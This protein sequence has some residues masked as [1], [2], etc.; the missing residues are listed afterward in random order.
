MIEFRLSV[1]RARSSKNGFTIVELLVVI[2]LIGILVGLLLPAVQAARGSAA[3]TQCLNNARQIALGLHQ[4]HDVHGRLPPDNPTDEPN[5]PSKLLH[6]TALILP[7]LEQA[8]LWSEA[9]Q[10]CRLDSASYNNPP[11]VGHVTIVKAFVCPS[12]SRLYTPL[13]LQDGSQAAFTS[14]IGI[15]GSPRGGSFVDLSGTLLFKPAAGVLGQDPG[16]RFAQISDGLS[17]TLMVGE[18]PPPAIANAGRWYSRIVYEPN[19]PGPDGAM[20]IPQ[21]LLF[22]QDTCEVSG[23]GFGPGRIDNPCDRFHFWSLHPG[24]GNFVF[25]DA[26]VRYVPYTA[27]ALL[28]ALATRAGDEPVELP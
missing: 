28:P 14:Y 25:A 1:R 11:H 2:G 7:H 4:H 23:R 21:H 12:D 6:W 26:S 17:Q 27:A 20:L 18:R 13:T 24:G 19:F 22:P 5:D 8:T 3:R 15:A 10:A 16:T 9:I